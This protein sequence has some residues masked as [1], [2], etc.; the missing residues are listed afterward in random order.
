MQLISLV[1]PTFIHMLRVYGSIQLATGFFNLVTTLLCNTSL[2][3]IWFSYFYLIKS[4]NI[5]SFSL[6]VYDAAKPIETHTHAHTQ[7]KSKKENIAVYEWCMQ[8]SSAQKC[9]QKVQTGMIRYMF[10]SFYKNKYQAA[11]NFSPCRYGE[12]YLG[13]S[14][15]CLWA[16]WGQDTPDFLSDCW[17]EKAII[18]C[19]FAVR[20]CSTIT[21]ERSNPRSVSLLLPPWNKRLK[22]HCSKQQL[23]KKGDK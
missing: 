7:K 14:E 17:K 16:C 15:S 22:W 5:I 8:L 3:Q 6:Y 1:A 9:H 18:S 10:V 23:K 13:Q 4:N 19:H 12:H 20:K 21:P 11:C 2:V